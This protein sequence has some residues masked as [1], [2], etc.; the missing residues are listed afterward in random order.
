MSNNSLSI[1]VM[2]DEIRALFGLPRLSE[3]SM[4]PLGES[5]GS[6]VTEETKPVFVNDPSAEDPFVQGTYDVYQNKIYTAAVDNVRK[7]ADQMKSYG[8]HQNKI[9]RILTI[10]INFI[11]VFF[12][13]PIVLSGLVKTLSLS[14]K[15]V[16]W[17]EFFVEKRGMLSAVLLL[18]M[19]Y[20]FKKTNKF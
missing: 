10:I 11:V 7:Q 13:L 20:A 9:I 3:P 19:M 15:K 2:I 6:D 5:L 14:R 17:E 18:I 16:D 4:K 8:N 1:F 12:F